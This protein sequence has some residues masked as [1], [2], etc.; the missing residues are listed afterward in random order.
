MKK[1]IS[2]LI[3]I[4]IITGFGTGCASLKSFFAMNPPTAKHAPIQNPFDTY[5]PDGPGNRE[6]IV[7]RTKK[8][9][10]SIEVELPGS[11]AQM[12]D[13]VVPVSPAFREPGRGLASDSD[14]DSYIDES[15]KERRPSISDREITNTFPQTVAGNEDS[16]REVETGLGLTPSEDAPA[17]DL[18]YLAATDHI[19]QLYKHARYEA[20][21]LELDELI[22]A[23]PTDPKLYEMRGT[24]FERT[25]RVALAVKSWNQALRLDPSNQSLRNFV[26]RKQQ[27]RS[28]A[29]P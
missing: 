14:G 2:A 26:E 20:A 7:L 19:K 18:S 21:L 4:E 22:R 25:G 28:I 13:F 9:D 29:S 23:Y 24:L 5:L 8:G 15:Y 1:S 6:N 3:I 12:T 27:K 16:R 11:T 17:A 10:R